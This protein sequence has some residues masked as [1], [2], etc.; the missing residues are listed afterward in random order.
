MKILDSKSWKQKFFSLK[1]EKLPH[2]L[3][4]TSWHK[5]KTIIF[6]RT[7]G[8]SPIRIINSDAD[9]QIDS[10]P[11]PQ[12]RGQEFS[13]SNKQYLDKGSAV[14]AHNFFF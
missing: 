9:D 6:G 4:K 8:R 12:N 11:D 7:Y 14:L 2:N 3:Q 5:E 1:S 13:S 10:D